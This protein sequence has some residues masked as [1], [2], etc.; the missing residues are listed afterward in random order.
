MT[1]QTGAL[2]DTGNLVTGQAS[3]WVAPSFTAPPPDS[4]PLF[5]LA[6]WAGITLNANGATAATVTVTSAL[7]TATTTS[8]NPTTIT[9]AALQTA[10]AGLSSVGAGNVLVTAAT[11][12]F[13]LAFNGALGSVTVTLAAQ[14]AGPAT[15]T[16][17]LW[18]P[19]GATDQGW[20]FTGTKQ[21][22]DITVE[23]QS[24]PAGVT[25]TSQTVSIPGVLA[26]DVMQSW[27]WAFNG[28]KLVT[29]QASGQPGKIRIILSDTIA[30]Y[31]VCLETVNKFGLGR[32]V[33]IP[34]SVC[35]DSPN[36]GFRRAANKRMLNVSFRSVCNINQIW[37]DEFTSPALP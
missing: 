23:E 9:A 34:D 28:T 4:A 13:R 37:V 19:A 10:L 24:A 26:E 25:M 8:I 35:L 27:Q 11:G 14:T 7:G 6:S 31:A 21:T 20:A 16:Q 22:T 2:Y 18:L 1:A 33:Y 12:G 5:D 3:L 32:R 15:V 29:A 36:V 30:R 17:A